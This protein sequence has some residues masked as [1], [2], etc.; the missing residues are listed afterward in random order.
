MFNYETYYVYVQLNCPEFKVTIVEELGEDW[1]TEKATINSLIYRGT[2]EPQ[3]KL[4]KLNST[5]NESLL[6]AEL[7][8]TDTDWRIIF[9]APT[10]SSYISDPLLFSCVETTC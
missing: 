3:V 5:L 1:I 7:I 4:C 6:V 2:G 10:V 8:K 9:K